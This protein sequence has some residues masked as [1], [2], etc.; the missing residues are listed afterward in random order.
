MGRPQ[1]RSVQA[2]APVTTAGVHG[3]ISDPSGAFIPG[4]TITVTNEEGIAATTKSDAAGAYAVS[5]LAPGS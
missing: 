5:N 3:H 4:A 2:A 1:R